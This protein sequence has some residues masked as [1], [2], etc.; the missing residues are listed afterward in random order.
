MVPSAD[1]SWGSLENLAV[2]SG[3]KKETGLGNMG[4]LKVLNDTKLIWLGLFSRFLQQDGSR[5]E[6]ILVSIES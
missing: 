4:H 3:K 6:C 5:N 2:R 1:V